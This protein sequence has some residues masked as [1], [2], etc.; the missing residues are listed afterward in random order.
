MYG[1]LRKL[2]GRETEAA[3]KKSS[4]LFKESWEDT[5]SWVS[6]FETEHIH[7]INVRKRSYGIWT[8]YSKIYITSSEY[9]QNF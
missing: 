6:V 3:L 2:W 7:F 5:F 1:Q 9:M 4:Q 8:E